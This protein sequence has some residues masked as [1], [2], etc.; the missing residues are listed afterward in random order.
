MQSLNVIPV[1]Q[2]ACAAAGVVSYRVP[3]VARQV[4]G[5]DGVTSDDLVGLLPGS[6]GKGARAA[7][8]KAKEDAEAEDA[9]DAKAV[10][11]TSST[12]FVV[13]GPLSTPM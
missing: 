3:L 2:F 11:D 13:S 10:V 4:L 6:L 12:I 9:K 1:D 7:K 5:G 8:Q